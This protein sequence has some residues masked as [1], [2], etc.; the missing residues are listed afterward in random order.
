MEISI[1]KEVKAPI[2]QVWDAWVTPE[3]ITNW[4]FATEEWCCPTAEVNLDVGGNFSYR[5][6]A[7]DGSMGFDFEGEFTALNLHKTIDY[8]LED[9]R[10]VSIEFIESENGTKIVETFDAEDENSG[11]Q[12]R[13]GWLGI[14]ENFKNYVENKNNN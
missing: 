7:K 5:M 13:Q 2:K 9:G 4:N 10:E 11:E 12:Q 3:D 8:K 1:E 14:L 6:E